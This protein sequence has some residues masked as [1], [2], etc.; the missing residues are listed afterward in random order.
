MLESYLACID[1]A[2]SAGDVDR[3]HCGRRMYSMEP[4][5][6]MTDAQQKIP[7][8][9]IYIVVYFNSHFF[10]VWISIRR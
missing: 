7:S 5:M 8:A 4:T 9:T 6:R 10:V 3:R 2:G 1:G